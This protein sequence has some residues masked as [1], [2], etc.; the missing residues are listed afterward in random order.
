[1][2]EQN[3]GKKLDEQ[4]TAQASFI[5]SFYTNSQTLANQYSLYENVLIEIENKYGSADLGK[6]DEGEKQILIETTQTLRHIVRLVYLDYATL[7]SGLKEK[8]DINIKN[9]FE[10]IRK[11]FIPQRD[12]VLKFVIEIKKV[13][14][15]DIIKNLLQ[16]SSDVIEAIYS[17][18]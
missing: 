4:K 15:K 7:I 17:N 3:K 16:N 5:L 12:T 13:I 18:G 14:V 10:E 11:D 2:S 8:E 1:M 6:M 9:Y